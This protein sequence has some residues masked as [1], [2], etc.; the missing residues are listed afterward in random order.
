MSENTTTPEPSQWLPPG[1]HHPAPAHQPKPV[2]KGVQFLG[3]VIIL[4]I[5]GGLWAAFGG[6]GKSDA[7]SEANPRLVE[8]CRTSVAAQHGGG[9]R[10]Y[11]STEAGQIRLDTCV[12][13]AERLT[14]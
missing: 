6:G 14:K 5:I 9:D 1:A 4:A 2:G 10:S 8:M 12:K 7:I 11:L 3:F 13:R